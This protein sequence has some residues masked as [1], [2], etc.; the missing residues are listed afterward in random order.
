ILAVEAFLR[1]RYDIPENPRLWLSWRIAA[2]L[3]EKIRPHYDPTQ[4]NYEGFLEELLAR[5]RAQTKYQAEF[6]NSRSS[7]NV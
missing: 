5:Y 4:F 1:R 6:S 3:L 7:L 2:P